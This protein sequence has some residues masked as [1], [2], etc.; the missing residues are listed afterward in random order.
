[1]LLLLLPMLGGSEASLSCPLRRLK[2]G[3]EARQAAMGVKLALLRRLQG[4][5][6]LRPMMSHDKAR[7]LNEVG[8]RWPMSAACHARRV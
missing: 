1:M 4:L 5:G 8:R 7:R 2:E 6:M 3:L